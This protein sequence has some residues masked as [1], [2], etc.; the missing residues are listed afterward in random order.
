MTIN[1]EVLAR[2]ERGMPS[3]QK[4]KTVA[5]NHKKKNSINTSQKKKNPTNK[6]SSKI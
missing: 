6:K 1:I 5:G 3:I 4:S 2:N